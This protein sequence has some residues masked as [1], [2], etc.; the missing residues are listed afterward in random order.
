MMGAIIAQGENSS[1][2]EVEWQ[3]RS[4]INAHHVL[5]ALR[6]AP[7]TKRVHRRRAYLRLYIR[8]HTIAL[9]ATKPEPGGDLS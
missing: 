1:T 8:S 4:N 7:S 9:I 6:D 5:P 3:V 2:V